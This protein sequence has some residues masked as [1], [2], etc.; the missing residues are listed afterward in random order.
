MAGQ[1]DTGATEAFA[2]GAAIGQHALAL[3][4]QHEQA[5]AR[6]QMA[7]QQLQNQIAYHA[8]ALG[9]RQQQI[10][11]SNAYHQAR[12]GQIGDAS[13]SK[14]Q[15][16]QD[17][18]SANYA[19]LQSLD[20]QPDDAANMTGPFDDQHPQP[21][22]VMGGALGFDPATMQYADP[23]AQQIAIQ[24]AL[25][26]NRAKRTQDMHDQSARKFA[27]WK[28]QRTLDAINATPMP[29]GQRAEARLI[30]AGVH[31]RAHDSLPMNAD[32]YT[33][34][35]AFHQLDGQPEAQ[36]AALD[37]F[38]RT[39]QTPDPK[40]FMGVKQSQPMNPVQQARLQSQ[41]AYQGYTA[42]KDEHAVAVAA[43]KDFDKTHA[44]AL[45]PPTDRSTGQPAP[46]TDPR[47]TA[48]NAAQQLRKPLLDAEQAARTQ[49]TAAFQAHTQAQ[50][51]MLA[52]AQQPGASTG[53]SGGMTIDDAAKAVAAQHPEWDHTK[54]ADAMRIKMEMGRLMGGGAAGPTT[55]D[56]SSPSD[57]AREEPDEPDEPDDDPD[58]ADD[59]NSILDEQEAWLT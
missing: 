22:G 1:F 44:A 3:R 49:R 11:N 7:Q 47:W 55:T 32:E 15:Q 26:N 27:D 31:M 52:Q 54:P 46:A 40:Q 35:P 19:A 34:S 25:S 39:G 42:A 20:Q 5:I 12:L 45:T 33:N 51:A 10:D 57:N 41:A 21:S 50:Q 14:Q 23:R 48:Y 58:D 36:Q 53:A 38:N 6:L 9:M 59:P 18:Q 29:E 4:Q 17:A 2:S 16:Y 8:Q 30:A 37:Y 28:Y 13:A 24:S 43:R 56:S